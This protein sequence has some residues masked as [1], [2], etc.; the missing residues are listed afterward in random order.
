MSALVMEQ[1]PEVRAPFSSGAAS[2]LTG[3]LLPHGLTKD[4]RAT[5]SK[6]LNTKRI[7]RGG[8]LWKEG[9][10]G[11]HLA[12]VVAGEVETMKETEFEGKQVILGL[13]RAGSVVGI[14][15]AMEGRS[16][17]ESARAVEDTELLVLSLENMDRLFSESPEF[18]VKLLR[19][20]LQLV[21]TRLRK[22][23]ERL[24]SFF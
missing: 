3:P 8:F 14:T 15:S 7:P 6:Y 13:H 17:E 1:E 22:S 2:R 18:A 12:L 19:K 16:R 20:M 4:E 9:E 11:D 21:S 5:V 23:V 24:A 10:S